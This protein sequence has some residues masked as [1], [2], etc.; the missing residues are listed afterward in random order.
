MIIFT[1]DIDW[2]P[3]EVIEDTLSLF[4]ENDVKCTL[5]ETHSSSVINSCSQTLF[6]IA[7]HPNFNSAI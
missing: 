2:A 5:F 4:E 6:E 1:C 3:E 7:I